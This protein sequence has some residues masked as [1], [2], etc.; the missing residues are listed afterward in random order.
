MPRLTQLIPPTPTQ[1]MAGTFSVVIEAKAQPD[2][3]PAANAD[4]KNEKSYNSTA[5]VC[6]HGVNRDNFIS[7]T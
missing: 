6:D 4:I 1:Q 7:S 5:P 3:S 2:H